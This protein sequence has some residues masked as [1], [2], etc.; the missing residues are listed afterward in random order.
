MPPAVGYVLYA[1]FGALLIQ[2]MMKIIRVNRSVVEGEAVPEGE[3]YRFSQVAILCLCY[4]V[5]FGGELA[6]EQM[7]DRKSVV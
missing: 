7:L 2:Q 6:V 4:G 3:K 1:L 5:T